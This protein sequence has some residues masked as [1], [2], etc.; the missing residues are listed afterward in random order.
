MSIREVNQE[1]RGLLTTNDI[2]HYQIH[3]ISKLLALIIDFLPDGSA[4]TAI[5]IKVIN[6][7]G[8]SEE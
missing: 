7:P 4:I 5:K 1:R 3:L 6:H 8:G 2:A